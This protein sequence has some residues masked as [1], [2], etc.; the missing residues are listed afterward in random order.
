MGLGFRGLY[1]LFRVRVRSFVRFCA[2][3][4]GFCLLLLPKQ[5][6]FIVGLGFRVLGLGFRVW[7]FVLV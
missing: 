7:G 6:V 1:K 5:F 3:L 2:V 4:G